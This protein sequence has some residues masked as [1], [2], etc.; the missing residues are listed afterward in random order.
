M[1]SMLSLG[2][3]MKI[4]SSLISK[5]FLVRLSDRL[6]V[7][8]SEAHELVIG[9]NIFSFYVGDFCFLIDHKDHPMIAYDDE[10]I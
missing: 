9:H 5:I 2:I 7:D 10:T 8:I 3:E 6:R 4:L 1:I